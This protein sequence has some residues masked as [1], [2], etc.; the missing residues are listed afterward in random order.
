MATRRSFDAPSEQYLLSL[1]Q[2][3]RAFFKGQDDQIDRHRR[4]RTLVEPVPIDE[5][6]KL[7]AAEVRDPSIW[8]ED[9][10]VASLFSVNPP[11]CQVTPSQP[12]SDT[13]EENA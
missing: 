10:H 6:F 9:Q 11:K 12:G 13:G 2:E 7:T 8:D 3:L 1:S 4:V 5:P